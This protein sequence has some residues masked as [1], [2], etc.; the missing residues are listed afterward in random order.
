MGGLFQ[1][2]RRVYQGEREPEG[3]LGAW[4]PD[5][6]AWVPARPLLSCVTLGML[7]HLSEPGPPRRFYDTIQSKP[8]ACLIPRTMIYRQVAGAS[9][10]SL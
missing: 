6:Q 2:H 7:P 1:C 4:G 3:G 8:A 9:Q 10:D 5:S